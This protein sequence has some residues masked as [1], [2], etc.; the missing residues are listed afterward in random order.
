MPNE[1][2]AEIRELLWR[3][4]TQAQEHAILLLDVHERLIW[5]NPTATRI[6]GMS[7]EEFQGL[8]ISRLFTP[9]DIAAGMPD[10]EA[11]IARAQGA[12]DDDRWQLRKDG[13]RFYASGAMAALRD[14]AGNLL[15]YGKVLRNRT[16]LKEQ[17]DLLRN[18]ADALQQSDRHKTEFLSKLSHE[19]RNP[20]APLVNAV[21][22]LRLAAPDDARVQRPV[23]IIE[24]QVQHIKRL[25]DDLLDIARINSGKLE[26]RKQAL[27]L[28]ELVQS[29][30]DAAYFSLDRHSH[31]F[32]ILKSPTPILIQADRTRMHQ[33]IVNL[34]TNAIKYTPAGGYIWVKPSVEAREAVLRIQDT[35]IGIEQEM[36]SRIFDLFTQAATPMSEGGLGI[37][38][39]LVKQLID[40]H[41]GTIQVVSDGPGKGSEFTIRLP[42]ES[43]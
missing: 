15:G 4:A 5:A 41:G 1:D 38:L 33:V 29:A 24:R 35:G 3:L 22:L 32:E 28:N 7:L 27:D 25:V 37:G 34:M 17:L 42:L 21:S 10:H 8:Q 43:R 12:S 2:S 39:S 11:A 40:L 19:L 18:Q 31:H 26:L 23:E 6:F 20:L 36:L 13:S 30:A 16:D 9:E 14:E